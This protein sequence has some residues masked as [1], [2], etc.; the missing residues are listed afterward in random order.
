MSAAVQPARSRFAASGKSSESGLAKT[1]LAGTVM[2]E[3]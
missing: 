3:V 1:S 2:A